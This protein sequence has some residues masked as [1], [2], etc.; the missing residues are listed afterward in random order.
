[1]RL[2][3]WLALAALLAGCA[4]ETVDARVERE[5][6][7]RQRAALE[8][9]LERAARPADESNVLITVSEPFVARLIRL[10]L[11]VETTV[12]DRIRIRADGA[13][14]EFDG[15]VALI[16]L[17]ARATLLE[18]P[19]I[20][21]DLDV[22]GAL[23]V[24]GV[25]EE[26]ATLTTRIAVLGFGTRAVQ[27][28]RLSPPAERLVDALAETPAEELNALLS[29]IELPVRLARTIPLPAVEEEEITIPAAS[30]PLRIQLHDVRVGEDRIWVYL[31]VGLPESGA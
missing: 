9:E 31:D 19:G 22:V 28:G 20:S 2:P 6:L 5:V 17:D 27:V 13:T 30:V 4:G 3:V 25:D 11:P 23:E 1:M 15:G 10:A 21:A 26:T 18:Q 8:R 12:D 29:R 16:R 24:L 7:E 14:V